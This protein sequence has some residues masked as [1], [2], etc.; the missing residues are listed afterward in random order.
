MLI[1]L[2]ATIATMQLRPA[3]MEDILAIVDLERTPAYRS[4]VGNWSVEEH[5]EKMG[6]SDCRYLIAEP[7]SGEIA[8]FAILRGLASLHRSIRLQRIVV[9]EP[10]QGVGRFMLSGILDYVFRELRA[11]RLWLDVFETNLRALHVYESVGFR[12]EG[13][14]REAIFRDGEYHT[15]ILM[16]MLDREYEALQRARAGNRKI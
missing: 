15:Q 4:F 14:L 1:A 2:D 10:Q 12:R 13:I 9:A 7:E 5:H 6:G 11:H 16:S 3:R 8:G